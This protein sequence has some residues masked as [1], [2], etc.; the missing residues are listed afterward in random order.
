[1]KVRNSIF[2]ALTMILTVLTV[3]GLIYYSMLGFVFATL[4]A[5]SLSLTVISM[6]VGYLYEREHQ[7][8]TIADWFVKTVSVMTLISIIIVICG[9]LFGSLELFSLAFCFFI[10]VIPTEAVIIIL[11]LPIR[12][13][14]KKIAE[15]NDRSESSGKP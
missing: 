9:R 3:Y 13:I 12:F 14:L 10:A 2:I 6:S 1:M 4:A 5:A 15:K 7:W 11:A 8:F